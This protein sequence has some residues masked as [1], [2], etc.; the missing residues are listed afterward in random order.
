MLVTEYHE[1]NKAFPPGVAD[2]D[3]L[4]TC[5][6]LANDLNRA[7]VSLDELQDLTSMQHD[8]LQEEAMKRQIQEMDLDQHK[9]A[10][11][12]KVRECY[13]KDQIIQDQ[14]RFLQLVLENA[15]SK[16]QLLSSLYTQI[17][18]LKALLRKYGDGHLSK[19]RKL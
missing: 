3:L 10:L 4:E 12:Q 17:E 19:K 2:Q 18:E 5:R 16:D 7:R 1:V 11:S 8:K 6:Q 9:E 14:G 15:Q 13:V